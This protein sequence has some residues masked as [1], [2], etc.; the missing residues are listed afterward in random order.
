MNCVVLYSEFC[1]VN[2][3]YG[4]YEKNLGFMGVYVVCND[5]YVGYES[6]QT[7]RGVYS[8]VP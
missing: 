8:Y 2:G 7:I 5:I 3:I 6:K 4:Y 1:S